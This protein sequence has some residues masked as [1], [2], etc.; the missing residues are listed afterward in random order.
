M[1]NQKINKNQLLTLFI[2]LFPMTLL[3]KSGQDLW[4][5]ARI[6]WESPKVVPHSVSRYRLCAWGWLTNGGTPGRST[7]WYGPFTPGCGGS[8]MNYQIVDTTT[9]QSGVYCKTNTGKC[10]VV[11][12]LA[13][14]PILPKTD[15]Y[16]WL[17]TT[18]ISSYLYGIL[19]PAVTT[20][21]LC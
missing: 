8:G 4:T 10:I 5:K 13:G 3:K 18:R 7:P 20:W 2:Y 17:T 19:Q 12:H 16:P 11:N 9:H 15:V 6:L 14:L 21:L 1:F